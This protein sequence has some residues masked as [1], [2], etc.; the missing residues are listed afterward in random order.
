MLRS[1][2]DSAL[3][4]GSAFRSALGEIK[5]IRRYGSGLAP[6]DEVCVP[7]P[8]HSLKEETLTV[9]PVRRWLVLSSISRL[10]RT[11]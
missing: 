2:Q 4:L 3:A 8:S 10:D 11:A 1:S 7:V 9:L 5:G 6:L